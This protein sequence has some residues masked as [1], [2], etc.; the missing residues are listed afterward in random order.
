MIKNCR[1]PRR[2]K[3]RQF[4]GLIRYRENGMFIFPD[5]ENRGNLPTNINFL[6]REFTP[7][8]KK[9]LRVLKIKG[10]TRTVVWCDTATIFWLWGTFWVENNPIMEWSFWNRFCCIWDCGL[11]CILVIVYLSMGSG[12]R[13]N[14]IFW[15]P[16]THG[17]LPW[18]E[19]GNRDPRLARKLICYGC[20]TSSDR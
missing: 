1:L 19:L 6:H 11:E 14:I 12:S 15:G 17:I 5:R 9:F 7:N 13:I 10:C 8:T 4:S 20:F 3:N 16:T 2:M 18:S